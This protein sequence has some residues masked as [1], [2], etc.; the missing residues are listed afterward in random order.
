M[1]P[2]D[3]AGSFEL[4]EGTGAITA[5]CPCG[6]FLEIYKIDKTFRIKTPESIDPERTNPN[7][8]WTA[9][10]HSDVGSSNP[11]IARVLLQSHEILNAASFASEVDKAAVTVHL[12]SCKE[13]LIASE[14]IAKRISARIDQI[15]EKIKDEGVSKDDRGRGLN[16]FPQVQELDADC[17]TFLIQANRAIKIISE[18][19]RFFLTL[20]KQDSNF[21]RLGN[22]LEAA[23]EKD[24]PII[25]FI[26][27]NAAYVSYLIDLRN[28]HEHPKKQ[29]RTIID[30]FRLMPDSTIQTPQ[31]H[32]SDGEPH[33]IKEEMLTTVAFLTNIAEGMLIHL[34][35]HCLSKAFPYIILETPEDKLNMDNPIRYRLSIDFNKMNF[36]SK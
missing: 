1:L 4:K 5:M 26:K 2:R 7:A 18:L 28:F 25:Q 22:R 6:E 20:D 8:L 12:H 21:D 24:A 33:P 30:N 19:P 3:S 29:R 31:W 14:V 9:S 32:L 11:I 13:A 34:V 36:P 35:M 27:A 10:P 23:L 16:P 15:I 17:G